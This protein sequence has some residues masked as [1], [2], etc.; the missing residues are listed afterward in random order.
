M[1]GSY[2]QKVSTASKALKLL[3]CLFLSTLTCAVLSDEYVVAD[4]YIEG[5]DLETTNFGLSEFILVKEATNERFTRKGLVKIDLRNIGTAEKVELRLFLESVA[6]PADIVIYSSYGIWFEDDVTWRTAPVSS[7]RITRERVETS[8]S[9]KW[10]AFDVTEAALEALDFDGYLSLRIESEYSDDQPLI[11]FASRNNSE[12][13]RH[14]HL[15]VTG[16]VPVSEY[17]RP[18]R[19]PPPPASSVTQFGIT[20]HFSTEHQIGQFANGDYY[21][22]ENFPGQ[23]VEITRIDPSYIDNDGWISNGSMANPVSG[24]SAKQG[25]D[26]SAKNWDAELNIETTLPSKFSAGTSIVSATSHPTAGNRPQ[27]KDAAVLTI[28]AEAPPEGAFRPP[29]SGEDKQIIGT[30]YDLDYSILRN[31]NL[32]RLGATTPHLLSVANE[33]KRPWIEI[34]TQWTG[35][36]LHP[37]NNQPD[38]GRD[39]AYAYGR[40]LL[41]LQLNYTERQKE[42]LYVRLVQH[43]IDIFGAVRTGAT[44]PNNG[45]HN[46]GR[47]GVM[48]LAGKALSNEDILYYSDAENFLGFQEDQQTFFVSQADIDATNSPKWD[49][50]DRAGPPEPYTE[51]HL[52]L[53]EWGINHASNRFRNNAAWRANYRQNVGASQIGSVLA[54]MLMGLEE[55]WNHPPLFDYMDRFWELEKENAKNSNNSIRSF[56]R[57]MWLY[58]RNAKLPDNPQTLKTESG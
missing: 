18:K 37:S 13:V 40:G 10:I 12:S 9:Q 43:G 16:L 20:W 4:S 35:R 31:F 33:F 56:V 2:S 11:S 55:T 15:V 29:Y 42:K 21:V 39:I 14:P 50:D 48:V 45:G 57:D 46:H 25:F 5:G 8:D 22:L 23:G 51:S 53:P 52:G 58:Y 38:Y 27:L 32:P 24:P 26:S 34:N 17:V 54:F 44:W 7:N 36:N 3:L 6:N 41:S 30:K 1:K 19:E 49:P 28:L 47:K